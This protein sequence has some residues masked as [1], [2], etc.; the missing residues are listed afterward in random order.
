MMQLVDVSFLNLHKVKA[1][2][3]GVLIRQVALCHA[4]LRHQAVKCLVK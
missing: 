2:K 1:E 3:N 4:A